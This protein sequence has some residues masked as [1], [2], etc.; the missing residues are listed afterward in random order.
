M[1]SGAMDTTPT[2]GPIL[3]YT[4]VSTEDQ[5]DHGAGLDAQHAAVTAEADRRGW[6]VEVHRE[7]A[8]GSSLDRRPVLAS[9]L[10]RLDRDGGVLVVAR[11][12]RL[13][14]SVADAAALMDRAR[15]RGWALVALDLGVDT[16]TPSGAL[17]GNVVAATAQYERDLIA[18][19]TREAL[20]ARRRAGTRL[21]RPVT[22]PREVRERIAR[23]R[24]EGRSLRAIADALTAEGVPTARG[25]KR[26]HAS[27]VRAVLASLDH[28]HAHQAATAERT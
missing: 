20:A 5:G 22:L 17:M 19:R 3:A 28:D 16:S 12:D 4:R 8:S 21:G 7:T 10:D 2:T 6:T 27:T 25:G 1:Y 18:A 23:D 24:A 9:L 11:L 13:S 15:R 14:R 26:W